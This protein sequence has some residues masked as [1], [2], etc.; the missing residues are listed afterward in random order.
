[1]QQNTGKKQNIFRDPENV[2]LGVSKNGDT[3]NG[4]FTMENPIKN[5]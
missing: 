2:D 3:Q 4:W 5:G 1:M